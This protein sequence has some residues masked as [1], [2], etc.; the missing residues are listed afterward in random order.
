MNRVMLTHKG[1]LG[2]CPIYIGE[3]KSDSPVVVPRHALLDWF[4][5]LHL[6]LVWC[7]CACAVWFGGGGIRLPSPIW[8]VSRLSPPIWVTGG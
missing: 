6:D 1:W 4:L 3:S 5:V 7:L 8:R 2:L